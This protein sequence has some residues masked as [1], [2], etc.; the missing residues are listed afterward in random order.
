[1]K[2][3]AKTNAAS[4]VQFRASLRKLVR[5]R[6]LADLF[7]QLVAGPTLLNRSSF[8]INSTRSQKLAARTGAELTDRPHRTSTF[9]G[10][11]FFAVFQKIDFNPGEGS[12]AGV[13][14]VSGP[15]RA[16]AL[17][18]SGDW[19]EQVEAWAERID[20]APDL[21]RDIGSRSWWRGLF[22]C[23]LLCALTISLSPG[24][25]AIPGPVPGSVGER[26]YDQ[27][28]AQ[29]VNA[30]AL[31]ADSG[32]HMGP[33]DAV[34]PLAETPERPRI[35][36]DAA[37][38]DGASLASTLSRS[39]V[40][41]V[42]AQDALVLISQAVTPGSIAAGTRVRMVL[43][44]RPN[45]NVARPLDKLAVRAKLEL[46]L[47]LNRVN[48]A[49]QMTRIPIAVDDTPLR[50]RG[51]VGGGLYRAARAAGAEPST[52]QAYLKVLATRLDIGTGVGADDQFD[53]IVAHRRAAT[54]ETETGALLYAGLNRGRGKNIDMLK[55][56]IDGHDQWFEASGVGESRGSLASP[57]SGGR[58][59]STYGA[60]M[61]PILGYLRM[62]AGIDIAAPYG[63]PIRAVADGTVTYSGWH[64]GHGNYVKVNHAGALATGYGHMSKIAARVGQKITRGQ[65]IGYVGS[66]GLSTGPHLHYELFKNGASIN[67]NSIKF[68]QIA[69]LS[70]KALA[71]F[72]SRLAQLKGLA[73]GI[74]TEPVKTA[75]AAKPAI[76][77]AMTSG[78]FAP[79][80]R[81][82]KAR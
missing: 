81:T 67:P 26:H 51:T 71:A 35:E 6:P 46:G 32:A 42:D 55:W 60:R 23:L 56:P 1:L 18:R 34:S 31:G 8:D 69:Q 50:I 79:G 2:N 47:E 33:T 73:A 62:H 44:R 70:G 12:S 5:T 77:S 19:R 54:G 25:R 29:M 53:M 28:R 36:L 72:K 63:T 37:I 13:L 43:G 64:G 48:G 3:G 4:L 45:R 61:H 49:L 39:G 82:T 7:A 11:V 10:S 9:G 57:V 24:F 27:Y 14:R 20:L 68:T 17:A 52:I 40:S 76:A 15:A 65:V 58:I 59:S 75:A 22:T 21:G 41:D 78:G 80:A 66:T 38:G 30:L 74:R 16:I